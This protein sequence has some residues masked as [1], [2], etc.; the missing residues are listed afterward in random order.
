VVDKATL[1]TYVGDYQ[2]APGFSIVITR[3]GDRLYGQATG[4][5]RFELFPESKTKFY[6]KV[7]EAQVTFSSNEKGEVEQLVLHQNG[8]NMPGKRLR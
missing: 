3:E 2:M 4:Q 8:Q 6:L 1:E 7:V 5:G